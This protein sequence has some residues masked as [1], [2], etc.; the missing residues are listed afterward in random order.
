MCGDPSCFSCG[1]AQG[2]GGDEACPACGGDNYDEDA[3]RMIDPEWSTCGQQICIE[4]VAEWQRQD[5]EGDR[6]EYEAWLAESSR[7]AGVTE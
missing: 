5:A 4:K 3:D 1:P 2:L 7:K 6:A